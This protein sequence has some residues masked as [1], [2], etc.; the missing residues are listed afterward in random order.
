[1]ALLHQQATKGRK[2]DYLR[3]YSVSWPLW[4]HFLLGGAIY[5]QVKR[6]ESSAAADTWG[7]RATWRCLHFLVPPSLAIFYGGVA[8]G[9]FSCKSARSHA[10]PGTSSTL[11]LVQK[12]GDVKTALPKLCKAGRNA[13]PDTSSGDKFEIKRGGRAREKQ[14]KKRFLSLNSSSPPSRQPSPRDDLSS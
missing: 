3:C 4:I 1:M 10:T 14:E 12:N 13:V 9:P 8:A 2:T 5:G 11:V 6:V 7:C